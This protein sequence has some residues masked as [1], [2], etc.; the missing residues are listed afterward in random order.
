MQSVK[1]LVLPKSLMVSLI[2]LGRV[3]VNFDQHALWL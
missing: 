3:L 2:T 1:K